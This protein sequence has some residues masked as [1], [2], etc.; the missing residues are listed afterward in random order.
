[1]SA[2]APPPICVVCYSAKFQ[3][4]SGLGWF[5][6]Q[7]YNDTDFMCAFHG[8][9]HN[10]QD[11]CN[12]AVASSSSAALT[13]ANLEARDFRLEFA[14][15]TLQSFKDRRDRS[16]SP[17]R[18]EPLPDAA[19]A[20]LDVVCKHD[21]DNRVEDQ[22]ATIA[23]LRQELLAKDAEIGSLQRGI[24]VTMGP[25]WSHHGRLHPRFAPNQERRESTQSLHA[26]LAQL[27]GDM[28]RLQSMALHVG[29]N[30]PMEDEATDAEDEEEDDEV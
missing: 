5:P 4:E 9:L 29:M 14:K 1:M 25:V 3:R 21:A 23:K 2:D 8:K 16:R 10:R 30:F 12:S 11:S 26:F 24:G 18:I 6:T 7:R 27:R 19:R 15:E 20:A 13:E 17:L 22:R 28:E